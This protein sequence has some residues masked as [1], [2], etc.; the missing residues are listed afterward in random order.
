MGPV[1]IGVDIGQRVDPTAIAVLEAVPHRRGKA[2]VTFHVARHLEG[3]P[4]GTPYPA[5][6]HRV[7]EIV[8]G[9]RARAIRPVT[10]QPSSTS[11]VPVLD[12]ATGVLR[13]RRPTTGAVMVR[14]Y[15]DA[16]GVG[17]PV[18]DLLRVA[19]IRPVPVYFTHGDRRIVHDDGVI[20][21]G[22]AWLVSRLQSVLQTGRLLLP[23]TPEAR[24]L[25]QEL[26]DY[27]IRVDRDANDHY[28][29]FRV[30]THDD[31]VTALGLAT[32]DDGPRPFHA[33]AG[34]PRPALATMIDQMRRDNARYPSP[35]RLD[36]LRRR[37]RDW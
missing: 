11:G 33:A 16:T 12:P 21:L 6:A 24:V 4:L 3:L 8:R 32:Q 20:T 28:G 27:E 23:E 1:T 10:K 31:L 13:V 37:A 15:A 17:Q 34:G 14:L 29:A 19:G 9:V 35:A 7:A 5:V 22:K 18:I 2:T 36:C 26:L 30:G 25:A